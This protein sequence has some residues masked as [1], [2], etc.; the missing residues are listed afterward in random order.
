MDKSSVGIL[1]FDDVEVLD[2]AGP[3]EVFSRARTVPGLES[4]W[5]EDSAPFVVFTVAKT[6]NA[7]SA[8]GNLQV[9]PDYDFDDA[10]AIDILVVPGG[11]G[12]RALLED[13]Q[14]LDWIK[15]VHTT[16]ALTSSVCTGSLVLAQSGL[17]ANRRATSHWGA[18][19]GLAKID[20]TIDVDREA[21]FVNDSI[22]TSA[23]VS[24]GIDMSFHIVEQ[25][26]GRDVADDTARFM[27][28]PLVRDSL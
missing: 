15:K 25:R 9:L 12:A 4:R 20:D 14:T 8:V 6:K 22:M 23:G 3:F 13:T 24:A 19:D 26:C 16:S 17:L 2:F 27:D 5:D 10:P 1:I 11:V 28:Y 18:L 7:I 21:R